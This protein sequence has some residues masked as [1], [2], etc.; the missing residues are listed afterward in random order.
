[1][2]SFSST[3]RKAV[4]CFQYAERIK[5]EMIIAANLL[6]KIGELKGDERAGAEKLM[7]SFLDALTGEV[8]LAQNVS[9]MRNFEE[10]RNKILEAKENVRL[11]EYS[12]ATKCISEAISF[13][14]SC[15]QRAAEILKEKGFI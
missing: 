8:N 13:A 9:G 11:H 6:T 2:T 15:G 4:V 12:R 3:I 7:L 5:S 10:A 1:M 14:T